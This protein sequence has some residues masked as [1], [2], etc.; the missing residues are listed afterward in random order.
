MNDIGKPTSVAICSIVCAL[1]GAGHA[2]ADVTMIVAGQAVEMDTGRPAIGAKIAMIAVDGPHGARHVT[3]TSADRGLFDLV[4]QTPAR[5]AGPVVLTCRAPARCRARAV[6]L[7]NADARVRSATLSEPV[8]VRS[9]VIAAS[10]A[11]EQLA[12]WHISAIVEV[13]VLARVTGVRPTDDIDEQMR[14]HSTAVLHRWRGR[15]SSARSSRLLDAVRREVAGGACRDVPGVDEQLMALARHLDAR[16]G[17]T[18]S[19]RVPAARPSETAARGTAEDLARPV[20]LA[21]GMPPLLRPISPKQLSLPAVDGPSV[22]GPMGDERPV[23]RPKT[24]VIEDLSVDE[25]DEIIVLTGSAIRRPTPHDLL[26]VAIFDR[27][28]LKASGVASVGEFLQDLPMQ[29]NGSNRQFNARGDGATRV[30]LRGLGSERTLVLINNRRY[31]PGGNGSKTSVDLNEVPMDLVERLEVLSGG[32]SAVHGSG[33]MSGVVNVVM[34][35]DVQGVEASGYLGSTGDGDGTVVD[36]SAIA[37][38]SD[39]RHRGTISVNFYQQSPIAAFDRDFSRFD[40]DFSWDESLEGGTERWLPSG[41]SATPAGL[42]VDYGEDV[43]NE[44]WLEVSNGSCPS[45]LCRMDTMTDFAFPFEND[46]GDLYNHQ[47]PTYLLTPFQR[48]QL[49]GTGSRQLNRHARAFAEVIF[50]RQMSA[51]QFAATPLFTLSEGIAVDPDNGYNPYGRT[52]IDIRRRA[53]ELGPRRA[54]ARGYTL[55]TV[56]GLEGQIPATIPVVGHWSWLVD[57]SFGYTSR[58]IEYRGYISRDHLAQGLGPSYI[59]GGGTHRCGTVEQPGDPACVPVNLFGGAGSITGNMASYL[60]A[61][62]SRSGVL[63]QKL[64]SLHTEG[65]LL[66]TPWDG[67]VR[68]AMGAEARTLSRRDRPDALSQSGDVIGLSVQPAEGSF[69]TQAVYGELSTVPIIDRPGARWLEVSGAVR[70]ARSSQFH[71]SRTWKLGSAWRPVRALTVRGV[72]SANERV[73]DMDELYAAERETLEQLQ[74]P[75]ST[76]N[77]PNPT[78]QQNCAADGVPS[79]LVDTRTQ[80]AVRTGGARRILA[81]ERAHTLDLRLIVE[82]PMLDGLR[83]TVGFFAL[84]ITQTLATPGSNVILARCYNRAIPDPDACAA[85]QRNPMTGQIEAI[86]NTTTNTTRDTETSGV[87]L[88]VEYRHR[89]RFGQFRHQ[90]LGTRLH[91]FRILDEEYEVAGVGVYDLGMFPRWKFNL[92]SRWN[93]RHLGAGVNLRYI[94]SLQEC[95]DNDCRQGEEFDELTNPPPFSREVAASITAD[96]HAHVALEHQ[97]GTT[98][99]TFGMNNIMNSSYVAIANGVLADSDA[100]TYDFAGRLAYVRLTQKF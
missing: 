36:V 20:P 82:P 9:T 6:P 54:E 30:D 22:P 67:D 39:A 38:V 11:T 91:S 46:L 96:V 89:T 86:Y 84:G 62:V 24:R 71:R 4:L 47:E 59:D 76:F 2:R 57:G 99:L 78:Q 44:A 28:D 98:V 61:P 17:A 75:C 19:A 83:L 80:L 31:L 95:Q 29:Y 74:D 35:T 81:A 92:G 73:P 63:Q 88:A 79:D 68:L 37:G 93:W 26:P 51:H 55:R 48:L 10:S 41:S 7:S 18:D 100:A 77:N 56:L 43:G 13:A 97:L 42:L 60:L 64:F 87:D 52:F 21:D 23:G 8:T 40:R 58:D 72:Y 85:I 1:F 34:R 53:V 66:K 27:Q 25:A 70:L 12:V 49:S 90:L 94:G 50:N 3:T 16:R 15:L 5:S 69:S 14:Q 65:Q 32:A 45:G 33:A